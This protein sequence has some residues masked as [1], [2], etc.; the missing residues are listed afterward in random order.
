MSPINVFRI[1]RS[2]TVTKFVMMTSSL[3][4]IISER[5]K[6]N[7]RFFPRNSSRAKANAARVI[8]TSIRAVVAT[9]KMRVFK[10]YLPRGTAEK[11]VSVYPDGGGEGI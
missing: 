7:T 3:G 6:R 9:V 11:A 8:T 1:L 4:I 2:V 5:N 10:K